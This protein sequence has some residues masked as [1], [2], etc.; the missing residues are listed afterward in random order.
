MKGNGTKHNGTPYNPPDTKH[1]LAQ[2]GGG[3]FDGCTIFETPEMP[4]QSEFH[5][6][7]WVS[8]CVCVECVSVFVCTKGPQ[9]THHTENTACLSALRVEHIT[10]TN[11]EAS[12]ASL[13]F[14]KVGQVYW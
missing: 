14:G 7:E 9:F 12:R 2:C 1:L 4:L 10:P 11:T 13:F 5:S 8:V 3:A 6:I